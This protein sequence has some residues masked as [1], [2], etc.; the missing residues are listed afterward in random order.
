LPEGVTFYKFWLVQ[1]AVIGRIVLGGGSLTN[2]LAEVVCNSVFPVAARNLCRRAGQMMTLSGVPKPLT[3]GKKQQNQ[4]AFS[5]EFKLQ[6]GDREAYTKQVWICRLLV[7]GI[8]LAVGTAGA[9]VEARLTITDD[10]GVAPS[11]DVQGL[12]RVIGRALAA[13]KQLQGAA[14][15]GSIEAGRINK[16]CIMTSGGACSAT[17]MQAGIAGLS[18]CVAVQLLDSESLHT[19]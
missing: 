15:V 12:G 8:W 6:D 10:K 7:A 13:S 14:C 3:V 18:L 2:H 17:C 16:S 5:T 1:L 19:C 4:P 9:A 11:A